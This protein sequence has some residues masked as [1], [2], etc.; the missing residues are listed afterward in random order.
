MLNWFQ[1]LL[2]D[3]H[4]TSLFKNMTC[5]KRAMC[6]LIVLTIQVYSRKINLHHRI[7]AFRKCR[8]GNRYLPFSALLHPKC[9]ISNSVRSCTEFTPASFILTISPVTPYTIPNDS[10]KSPIITSLAV[11]ISSASHSKVNKLFREENNHPSV[12]F[13]TETTQL[14]AVYFFG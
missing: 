11:S 14:E 4:W 13:K 3:Q 6:I 5:E 1:S 10:S 8:K 7:F 9:Q 2:A 12:L